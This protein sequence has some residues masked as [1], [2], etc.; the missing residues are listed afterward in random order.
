MAKNYCPVCLLSEVSKVF[1]KLLNNM[2]LDHLQKCGLQSDFKYAFRTSQSIMNLL[3]VIS[4]SITRVV[5]RSEATRALEAFDRVWHAGFLHQLQTYGISDQVF[6]LISSFFSNRQLPVVLDWK[7][8]QNIQLMLVF[9]KAPFLVLRFSYPLMTFLILSVILLSMLIILLS[10]LSVIRH[11]I[12]RNNQ[13]QLL[14]LNLTY[15][16]LQTWTGNG[17]LI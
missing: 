8:S 1:E 16:T 4:N 13:S 6:G 7:S 17:L 14:N 9:L 10:T 3:T 15:R 2:L 11:M 12:C 5:S